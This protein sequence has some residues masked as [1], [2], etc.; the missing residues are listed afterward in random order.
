MPSIRDCL[1]KGNW[2]EQ[3]INELPVL[4][5]DPRFHEFAN[6]QLEDSQVLER[7]VILQANATA[8]NLDEILNYKF[9]SR[10]EKQNLKDALIATVVRDK[11][12]QADY[13]SM[14]NRELAILGTFHSKMSDLMDEFRITHGGFAQDKQGLRNVFKEAHTPG[15]TGDDQAAWY[16]KSFGEVFEYG[17]ERFNKAGG[18]IRR[19]KNYTPQTHISSKL[20][21]AGRQPWIE[22]VTPRLNRD[23]MINEQTG[24]RLD[25]Q[26]LA[27]TLDYVFDTITTEGV[28]RLEPGKIPPGVSKAFSKSYQEHRVLHF[29]DG[30]IAMEYNDA[31]G[32]EDLY[33]TMMAHFTNLSRK[34]AA[35]ET[36]GPDPDKTWQTMRD[37]I[38][39]QT[40]DSSTTTHANKIYEH[41][42]GR[43]YEHGTVANIGAFM[44][45]AQVTSKLGSTIFAS[46]GDTVTMGVIARANRLPV[47]KMMGRFVRELNPAMESDRKFAADMLLTAEYALD[48]VHGNAAQTEAVGFKVMNK[49]TDMTMRLGAV[50]PWTHAAK[51]AYSLESLANFSRNADV[52]FDDLKPQ[53]KNHLSKGGID[54]AKWDLIRNAPKIKNRGQSYIDASKIEDTEAQTALIGAIMNE[55]MAAVIEPDARTKANISLGTSSGTWEGEIFRSVGSLKSHPITFMHTHLASIMAKS[56]ANKMDALAY[57]SQLLVG[58]SMVGVVGYQLKQVANGKDP[59]DWDDPKLW[60]A[61]FMMGGGAAIYG[62]FLFRDQTRYG[63]NAQTTLLGPVASDIDQLVFKLMLGN[64]QE[65]LEGQ[66]LEE[67][68]LLPELTK[69]VYD[70]I[71]LVSLWPVKLALDRAIKQTV[72]QAVDPKYSRKERQLMRKLKKETK[73]KYWWKPSS[74]TPDRPPNFKT[75]QIG[76]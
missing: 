9:A 35:M 55:R 5:E 13:L 68:R 46:L 74:A 31:F 25:D 3:Q 14:S 29:K 57:T 56:S 6:R 15:S 65:L 23:L 4:P 73:Q 17:V 26:E 33:S 60:G 12:G 28:I 61:G 21:K 43:L 44:R 62:D 36:Y 37:V 49:L 50:T 22:F 69:N 75:E 24:L 11:W 52:A 76:F 64:A 2:T 27:E 45:M 54:A 16:A 32:D 8:R 39:K 63:S 71:P 72:L 7:N 48:G 20:I 30:N 18:A 58:L 10:S 41:Q 51:R 66:S 47:M 67:S 19:M 38:T 70:R 53:I 34:I 59:L 40:G 1:L 42:M